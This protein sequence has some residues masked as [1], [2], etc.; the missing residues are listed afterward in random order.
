LRGGGDK[1]EET[2]DFYLYFSP[3][4]FIEKGAGGDKF[5]NKNKNRV[6]KLPA[7]KKLKLY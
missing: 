3:A 5:K 4:P 1:Q 7:E 2:F 6:V